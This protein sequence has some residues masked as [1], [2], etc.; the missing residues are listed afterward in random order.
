[1]IGEYAAYIKIKLLQIFDKIIK[2]ELKDTII[3]YPI[4][5]ACKL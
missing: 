4:I 5:K 1:M 2:L 3:T